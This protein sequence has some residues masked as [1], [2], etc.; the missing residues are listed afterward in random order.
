MANSWYITISKLDGSQISENILDFAKNGFGA[1]SACLNEDKTLLM[2]N[3]ITKDWAADTLQNIANLE[4][5]LVCEENSD[6]N[7]DVTTITASLNGD[8]YKV[9]TY[10]RHFMDLQIIY[11]KLCENDTEGCIRLTQQ[12]LLDDGLK[13]EYF[14][15][16]GKP[17][18]VAEELVKTEDYTDE[19]EEFII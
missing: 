19:D 7:C 10:N 17:I 4:N 9:A 16:Y 13:P 2:V 8:W 11:G 14:T 15:Q 12:I 1:E 3:T 18:Y 6:C 5:N